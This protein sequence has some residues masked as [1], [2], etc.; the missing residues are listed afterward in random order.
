MR[1]GLCSKKKKKNPQKYEQWSLL[2]LAVGE[3]VM[4]ELR[5]EFEEQ[6][7]FAQR[8]NEHIRRHSLTMHTICLK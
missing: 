1:H 8:V 6:I 4:K 7:A 3:R 5:R 2:F